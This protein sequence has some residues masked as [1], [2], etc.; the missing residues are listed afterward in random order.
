[1]GIPS[2]LRDVWANKRKSILIASPAE[3]HRIMTSKECTQEGVREGLKAATLACVATAIPTMVAV[4]YVPWVKVN[5][6]YTA[7]ALIISAGFPLVHSSRGR[8]GSEP[9]RVRLSAEKLHSLHTYMTEL[10]ILKERGEKLR[11]SIILGKFK[12]KPKPKPDIPITA[13]FSKKVPQTPS[14]NFIASTSN[15]ASRTSKFVAS[16]S[17]EALPTSNVIPSA[18]NATSPISNV[19]ESISNIAPIT[20]I[21]IDDNERLTKISRIDTKEFDI[22]SLE[23]DPAKRQQIYEYHVDRSSIAAYFITAD[24]TILEC[25][26]RNSRVEYANRVE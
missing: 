16:T 20:N 2:E 17:K 13:F 22:N 25:A 8:S 5:L 1:M 10:D 23:W 26:R 12:P 7:Q 9:L 18:S 15:D 11:S 3:E 24:K 14:S 21:A 19:E 6:N 4:R